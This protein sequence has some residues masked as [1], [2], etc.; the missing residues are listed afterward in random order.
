MS[1]HFSRLRGTRCCRGG[2]LRQHQLLRVRHQ[3]GK[4]IDLGI[5]RFAEPA[6]KAHHAAD[7]QHV[8]GDLDDGIFLDSFG[9]SSENCSMRS[10]SA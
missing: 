6:Q 4:K 2:C 1:S 10:L 7:Q 5:E 8:A 3:R 9:N